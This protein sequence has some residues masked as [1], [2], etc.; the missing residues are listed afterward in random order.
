MPS[1]TGVIQARWLGT[2]SMTIRHSKHT[3]IKQKGARGAPD[4]AVVRVLRNEWASTAAAAVSPD[5]ARAGSPLIVILMTGVDD[6]S[7]RL[8]TVYKRILLFK[9]LCS[10]IMQSCS[11]SGVPIW[12][13]RARLY[14][15]RA[16]A[17]SR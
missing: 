8:N 14:M 6:S 17:I 3:P 15:A 13:L 16:I 4:T 10:N 12:A 1:L 9:F 2:P 7:R 11:L 5:R